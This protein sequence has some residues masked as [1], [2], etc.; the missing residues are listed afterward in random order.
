VQRLRGRDIL[1]IGAEFDRYAQLSPRDR[2]NKECASH[3]LVICTILPDRSACQQPPMNHDVGILCEPNY[4]AFNRRAD[5]WVESAQLSA[6]LSA[7]FDSVG[8]CTWR[9]F[10]ALNS[11]ARSWRRASRNS[12]M[13]CGFCAVNQSS[14]SSRVSTDERTETGISTVSFGIQPAYRFSAANQASS[15]KHAVC[16]SCASKI[17]V[18]AGTK[19]DQLS[20]P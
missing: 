13:S 17:R 10:H 5:G 12:A 14:N 7:Y 6:G 1:R 8:H 19:A 2:S 15:I 4:L 20:T 11:P 9:G 16:G 18:A 3:L